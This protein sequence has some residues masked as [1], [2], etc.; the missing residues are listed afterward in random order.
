MEHVDCGWWSV[1][2]YENQPVFLMCRTKNTYRD[3][4]HI[5]V[6]TS[7]GS[8]V[9]GSGGGSGI[10]VV[11]V[12]IIGHLSIEF[13]GGLWLRTCALALGLSSLATFGGIPGNSFGSGLGLSL[14]VCTVLRQWS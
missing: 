8:T 6:T 1:L 9:G 12:E 14:S 4:L 3:F 11:R 5:V 7:N 13:F 2:L 10:S